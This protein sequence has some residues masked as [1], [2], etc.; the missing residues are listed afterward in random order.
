MSNNMSQAPTGLS[1]AEEVGLGKLKSVFQI[2]F[3]LTDLFISV[4]GAY[5]TI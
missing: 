2:L 4:T 3:I 1:I 5:D